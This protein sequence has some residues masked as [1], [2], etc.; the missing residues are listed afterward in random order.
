M[1]K[2][3]KL[4]SKW[5]SFEKQLDETYETINQNKEDILFIN[6][7]GDYLIITTREHFDAKKSCFYDKQVLKG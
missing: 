4:N 7:I 1:N 3:Y 5:A 2:V 6:T